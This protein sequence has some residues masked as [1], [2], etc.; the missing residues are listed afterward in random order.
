MALFTDGNPCDTET[1]RG[2][3]TGILDVANVEGI[4]LD[5]KL[6]LATEEVGEELLA[7]L[8]AQGLHD[9]QAT[10][11]R[12][13]GLSTVVVTPALRRWHALHTLAMVYRDAYN[14]QLNDR[15]AGKRDQYEA[16]KR[17]AHRQLLD[18]GIGLVS[19]PAPKP[20]APQLRTVAG[21]LAAGTYFVQV[22]WVNGLEE[23]EGAASDALTI[24]TP[25]GSQLVV[26]APATVP[27]SAVGYNV[28]AGMSAGAVM[29]QNSSP[30]EVGAAWTM[31][32]AG[33]QAG[34]PPGDGQTPEFFL[35][36][37]RVLQRG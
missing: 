14:N 23:Q 12:N 11:R 17:A 20:G 37:T 7:I 15:Y 2:Y 4:D 6:T 33:L 27:S 9:P 19:R 34:R 13:L 25:A 18:I 3:E 10:M 16:L 30:V 8:L 31:P 21:S 22:S 5:A 35:T 24:E 28:Y 32:P 29:L 36:C 26:K 1:L